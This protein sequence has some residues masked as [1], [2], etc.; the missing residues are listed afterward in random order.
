MCKSKRRDKVQSSFSSRINDTKYCIKCILNASRPNQWWKPATIS[1]VWVESETMFLNR[2]VKYATFDSSTTDF[3]EVSALNAYGK[4]W[5][6]LDT[7]PSD[8]T[9]I[10]DASFIELIDA[11]SSEFRNVRNNYIKDLE[12][13]PHQYA[14]LNENVYVELEDGSCYAP[15]PK[16]NYASQVKHQ[17]H[18]FRNLLHVERDITSRENKL[19]F[20]EQR[21]RSLEQNAEPEPTELPQED[22]VEQKNPEKRARRC[23]REEDTSLDA[24][25]VPVP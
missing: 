17:L 15:F 9:R 5:V 13:E 2:L 19:R 8:M 7:K 4:V 6:K 14:L 18:C 24:F 20:Q 1:T 22:V 16:I 3:S 21:A 11:K 10:E 12:L 23:K 25:H